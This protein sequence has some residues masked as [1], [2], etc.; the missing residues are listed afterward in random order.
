MISNPGISWTLKAMRS[1][2]VV[3]ISL[4]WVSRR[5]EVAIA[6]W[7][8]LSNWAWPSILK[9][10]W[11]IP[12]ISQQKSGMYSSSMV[13]HSFTNNHISMTGISRYIT[14]YRYT[15][16]TGGTVSQPRLDAE[17]PGGDGAD[18]D[19]A[20]WSWLGV[21]VGCREVMSLPPQKKNCQRSGGF[22]FLFWKFLGWKILILRSFL[23]KDPTHSQEK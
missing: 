18:P 6:K 8:W 13:L 4:V 9:V 19:D 3:C 14:V 7:Q 17:N 15:G 21:G 5:F 23:G 2:M 20:G 1:R 12:V 16:S 10:S 11:C 22:W